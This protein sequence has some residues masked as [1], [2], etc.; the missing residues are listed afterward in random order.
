MDPDQVIRQLEQ[1]Q[2]GAKDEEWAAKLLYICE[3]LWS[4]LGDPELFERSQPSSH[5]CATIPN[6]SAWRNR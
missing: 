6:A 3:H 5:Y 4:A 2:E 1:V